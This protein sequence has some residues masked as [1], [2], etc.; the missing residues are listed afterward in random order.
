MFHLL[1][2]SQR[3]SVASWRWFWKAFQP[4]CLPVFPLVFIKIKANIL[5]LSYPSSL[6]VAQVAFKIDHL[7]PGTQDIWT[8]FPGVK[9]T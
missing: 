7:E 3:P 6:K 5:I 4:V 2:Q 1:F 9:I 8:C